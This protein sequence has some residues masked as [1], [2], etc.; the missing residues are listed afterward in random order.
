MLAQLRRDVVF[1][2]APALRR[3][4]FGRCASLWP[5]CETSGVLV[6]R[7]L[8][9]G[10]CSRQDLVVQPRSSEAYLRMDRGAHDGNRMRH[11]R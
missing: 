4:A 3:T 7:V 10:N 9:A 8:L 2:R 1:R 11:V 6:Y 5:S